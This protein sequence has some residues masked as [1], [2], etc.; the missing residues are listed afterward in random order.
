MLQNKEKPSKEIEMKGSAF[1]F[2]NISKCSAQHTS[3][4]GV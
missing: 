1:T 3:S 4:W 2:S